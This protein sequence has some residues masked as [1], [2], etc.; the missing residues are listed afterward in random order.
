MGEALPKVGSEI[1]R[2]DIQEQAPVV[3]REPEREALDVQGQ[4]V[5]EVEYKN[6]LAGQELA[7]EI[8][9]LKNN[10]QHLRREK[11]EAHA[12]FQG[13]VRVA[14]GAKHMMK[15]GDV[16]GFERS[17]TKELHHSVAT[18]LREKGYAQSRSLDLAP[19]IIPPDTQVTFL[20]LNEKQKEILR[21]THLTVPELIERGMVSVQIETMQRVA[22]GAQL[23]QEVYEREKSLTRLMVYGRYGDPQASHGIRYEVMSGVADTTQKGGEKTIPYGVLHEIKDE[24]D[25]QLFSQLFLDY[26]SH[27]LEMYKK[28]IDHTEAAIRG[29]QEIVQSKEDVADAIRLVAQYPDTHFALA[30]GWEAQNAL[31]KDEIGY[32]DRFVRTNKGLMMQVQEL[33]KMDTE[34]ARRTIAKILNEGTITVYAQ[35]PDEYKE[36]GNIVPF[37]QRAVRGEYTN[38]NGGENGDRKVG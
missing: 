17:M 13:P 32:L 36:Q 31:E 27:T 21:E 16:G 12:F 18:W 6:A 20:R 9:E 24:K 4:D 23:S 3:L 19:I 10:E 11:Q 28:D 8:K 5:R 25:V 22:P 1:E 30:F 38:H 33:V 7:G 37:V 34:L 14:F 35:I 26:H 2:P 29:T 15:E